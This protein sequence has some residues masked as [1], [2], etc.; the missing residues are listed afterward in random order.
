MTF[1]ARILI[2]FLL[3]TVVPIVALGLLVRREMTQRL[4][5][6]YERR[7]D[8]LVRVVEEDLARTRV[9]VHE[10]LAEI[11][12]EI[13]ADN[14]FRRAAMTEAQD[15]RRYLLDYATSV[16]PV[17]GL[18]MLQIQ[19]ESGRILSSGHFRNDYDR[20]NPN[21]PRLLGSAP[22]RSALV[23]ARTPGGSFLAL[24][25]V[26]SVAMGNRRFVLVGGV[27][28]ESRF[29][30]DLARDGA[31]RV[32]LE[33]PGDSLSAIV[34]TTV[35]AV[36]IVR[37]STIPFADTERDALTTATFR[38]AHATTE[39]RALRSS[40]DRWFVI[41]IALAALLATIAAAWIASRLSRPLVD[42]AEKTSRIDLD[43]LDV[44][45]ANGRKDEI[46]LLAGTLS[47]L[48]A[49]LRESTVQLKDA[50]RR[51]TFGDLAR[52]VNHDIK[53]GLTPI[54]NVFRHLSQQ[55]K[56]DPAKLPGAFDERSATLDASIAY[57]ENLAT[58]YARLSRR[59]DRTR[60]D[61]NDVV[62]KI[63]KDRNDPGKIDVV[64]K[65]AG[66]AS[67]WGDDVS[68]RRV[69]ENLVANAI[70]SL[71]G[72][73]RVTITTEHVRRDRGE[74]R[75]RLTVADT[76]AGMDAATRDKIF[77][78]FYTTKPEGT[79]LGLSIVRRLMMDLDGTIAVES[80]I[81]KGSRFMVEFPAAEIASR[82][83]E[84]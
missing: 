70:E 42:L 83:V 28:A 81:G 30:Q 52:Q 39:L 27:E 60:C 51:A 2:A 63:S 84:S 7:V 20:V 11:G 43:R 65:L 15:E 59:G 9:S 5:S 38:V 67:V 1:R 24:A 37:T 64:T 66:N 4:T 55:S 18:S 50:E 10:A 74:S 53:N 71:G 34:D 21:L 54:R 22:E 32:S 48:T 77:D 6:Q 57:L 29:L 62:R 76:G 45:F 26:D 79:G 35:T 49:R 14:R 12:E 33:L 41:A 23:R 75:V 17:A 72:K 80:E 36:A 19:D 16:M 82:K 25:C 46:G 73:G 47:K 44:D 56:E 58:N 78:D 31:I 13:I 69:V 61:I 68:V 40:I 3:A 8:A